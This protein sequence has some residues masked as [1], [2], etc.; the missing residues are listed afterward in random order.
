MKDPATGD[1]GAA[2]IFQKLQARKTAARRLRQM[3]GVL[4]GVT[5]LT[6]AFDK[7]SA[8]FNEHKCQFGLSKRKEQ[9]SNGRCVARTGRQVLSHHG[10]KLEPGQ[11]PE[12]MLWMKTE[13]ETQGKWNA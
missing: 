2:S 9:N 11:R 10:G 7:S 12:L 8:M 4:F 1:Q 3:G 6:V 13:M 5:T